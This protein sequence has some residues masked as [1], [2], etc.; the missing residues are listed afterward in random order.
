MTSLMRFLTKHQTTCCRR[1]VSIRP[2]V[3]WVLKSPR[4][5]FMESTDLTETIEAEDL[6]NAICP[7]SPLAVEKIGMVYLEWNGARL[8]QTSFACAH[9]GPKDRTRAFET[10]PFTLFMKS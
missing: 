7:P 4:G 10:R 2:G 1:M 9:A 3:S 8:F 6:L 5:R